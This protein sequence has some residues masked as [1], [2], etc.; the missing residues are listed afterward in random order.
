MLHCT[1]PTLT[2]PA[3]SF[4][5]ISL[6][7][8]SGI[9]GLGRILLRL[10][11][12]RIGVRSRAEGA[13][14]TMKMHVFIILRLKSGS[15]EVHVIPGL[16]YILLRRLALARISTATCPLPVQRLYAHRWYL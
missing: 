13:G 14:E 6:D 16:K 1:S 12:S 2:P 8:N 10:K 15:R 11:P 7:H 4:E 5:R 9:A 3:Q